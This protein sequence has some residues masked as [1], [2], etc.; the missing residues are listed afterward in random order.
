LK[1]GT[2]QITVKSNNGKY[3]VCSVTVILPN[4]SSVSLSSEEMHLISGEAKTLTA[5]IYPDNAGNKSITWSSS[6]TNVAS[7]DNYGNVKGVATGNAVIT[8]TSI[9]GKSASC[10]VTVTTPVE[11]ISLPESE[12]TASVG[13]TYTVSP[14]FKPSNADNR[15]F[16][17]KVSDSSV[18]SVKDNKFTALKAGTSTLTVTT[19]NGKSDTCNVTV[20]GE[21]SLKIKTKPNKTEYYLGDTFQNSS[22]VL[23]YT[24]AY[25]TAT[26]VSSGY[27][28]SYNMNLEGSQT[29]S[30]TYKDFKT[31]FTINIKRPSIKLI[32]SYLQDKMILSVETDP[33]DAEFYWFSSDPNIF[34]IENGRLTP[35]SSGTAYAGVTMVYNGKEYSDSCPITI[36]VQEKNYSLEIYAN[37]IDGE[38]RFGIE[39]D[40]PDFDI[41]NVEWSA[42]TGKWYIDDDGYLNVWTRETVKVTASYV[43]NGKEYS[44]SYTLTIELNEYSLQIVR[45][46]DS[47]DVARGIYYVITDIP[48]FDSSNVDWDIQAEHRGGWVDGSYYYV[49]EC[50][51]ETG[52]TYTVFAT[53]SDNTA[54]V[55]ASFTF[56]YGG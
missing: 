7:V 45:S 16:T 5:T 36:E 1:A 55:T 50:G 18:L 47:V 26:D 2:A 28:L 25:G 33:Y 12:F 49:D 13:K 14:V 54:S 10:S 42:D 44:D 21:A 30:V 39:T 24:D 3:A 9:N 27:D 20:L 40:I 19:P 41:K 31:S 51:M 48:N 56:T 11:S 32:K 43:Y 6:N 29:V 22:L 17:V 35:V 46:S 34:T 8:A 53:Y 23:S 37:T 38:W 4:I 15:S 52:E